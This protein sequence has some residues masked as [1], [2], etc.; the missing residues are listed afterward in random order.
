MYNVNPS[1]DSL[2]ILFRPI[3]VKDLFGGALHEVTNTK[4]GTVFPL[5]HRDAVEFPCNIVILSI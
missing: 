3:I 5:E 2:L 4:G 1:D